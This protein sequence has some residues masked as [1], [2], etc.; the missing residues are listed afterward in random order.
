MERV[1]AVR[2]AGLVPRTERGLSTHA[3]S[4]EVETEPLVGPVLSLWLY[5]RDFAVTGACK[6]LVRVPDLSRDG[7]KAELISPRPEALG[8]GA[9]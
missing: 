7:E 1:L 9:L 3:C 8:C 4:S 2:E 6:Y 5:R